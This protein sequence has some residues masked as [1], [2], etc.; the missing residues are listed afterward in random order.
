MKKRDDDDK[1]GKKSND[2]GGGGEG[3]GERKAQGGTRR[4]EASG[5]KSSDA[6][7][8]PEEYRDY[9]ELFLLYTTPQIRTKQ[10]ILV[11][12][13]MAN[14]SGIQIDQYVI[15]LIGMG[16]FGDVGIVMRKRDKKLAAI[17]ICDRV[18]LDFAKQEVDIQRSLLDNGGDKFITKIYDAF[19]TKNKLAITMELGTCGS[20][21]D[22]IQSRDG[23]GSY[24]SE[25]ESREVLQQ[26]FMALEHVHG[27]EVVSKCSGENL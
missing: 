4:E 9:G 23:S 6:C 19:T 12:R 5:S 1:S 2:A 10:S 17:K 3:G 14:R 22:F 27:A 7:S 25:A 21:Q 8:G 13:A 18:N 11:K 20:L 26:T 24:L 16:T 15:P